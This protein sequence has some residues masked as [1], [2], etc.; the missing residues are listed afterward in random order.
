MNSIKKSAEV[1]LYEHGNRIVLEFDSTNKELSRKVTELLHPVLTYKA[2]IPLTGKARMTAI[3]S[4]RIPVEYQ[5]RRLF[6]LDFRDRIFFSRGN[7]EAVTAQLQQAGIRTVWINQLPDD[8]LPRPRAFEF[9]SDILDRYGFE[10]RYRQKEIISLFEKFRYGRIDA[11]PG[12]GKGFIITCGCLVFPYAKIAVVTKSTA[13]VT[14]RLFPEIQSV[15]PRTGIRGAGKNIPGERVTVYTADSLHHADPYT[16]IIFGDECHQLAADSYAA[17][18]ANFH[19]ARFWGFSASHDMRSDGLDARV[20]AIFGP[21]RFRMT[22]K[23][24]AENGLVVPIHVRWVAINDYNNPCSGIEI[25]DS[26]TRARRGVWAYEKRNQIIAKTAR[27]YKDDQILITVS[28]IEHGLRLQKVLPE[29]ELVYSENGINKPDLDY[30]KN[31]GLVPADYIPIS[32]ERRANLTAAFESGRLKKAIANQVWNVGVNFQNLQT[33]IRADAGSS[34]INNIQIP[35]RASRITADGGKK[36]G[37]IVDFTD[38]HD[39]VLANRAIRRYRAYKRFDWQQEVPDNWPPQKADSNF[40][41]DEL[42]EDL[43]I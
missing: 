42:C 40:D 22:Y 31:T 38:E 43:D 19:H 25:G 34:E 28:S 35:G 13:V 23:E 39:S 37:Q 33:L 41:R 4:G 21:V 24:A 5:T 32:R 6:D 16:D 30:Y 10:Y 1:Y 9:R 3:R 8:K 2:V 12:F 20:N 17:K 14:Q 15:L 26:V 7:L 36:I 18:L 11:P 29:F 27:E